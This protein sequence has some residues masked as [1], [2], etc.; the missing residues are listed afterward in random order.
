[1]KSSSAWMPFEVMCRCVCGVCVVFVVCLGGG[2]GELFYR[3][4]TFIFVIYI[5]GVYV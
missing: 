5:Y 3:T 2:R 4:Y 1:M